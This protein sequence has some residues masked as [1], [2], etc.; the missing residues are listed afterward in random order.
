MKTKININD[1]LEELGKALIKAL[2]YSTYPEER[3]AGLI[4][5]IDQ[6]VASPT[7]LLDCEIYFRTADSNDMLLY[8]SNILYNLKMQSDFQM[9]PDE[10]KWLGSVWKNFLNRNITYQGIFKKVDEYKIKFKSYYQ[11]S[12]TFINQLENVNLI[13]EEFIDNATPENT[14]LINLENFYQQISEILS[15]MKP[16]YYFMLDYYYEGGKDGFQP[17]SEEKA[18]LKGLASFGTF[19]YTYYDLTILACQS[20]GVLEAAYLIMKKKKTSKRIITIDG[21][22]KFLST[23]EIYTIYLNKFGDMKKELARLKQA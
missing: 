20:L 18:K 4:R 15:W 5:S 12:G 16:T 1:V 6:I 14:P 3:T 9:T 19:N 21:K 10:L 13:K 7:Y 2:S 22:Q 8:I 23:S 11:I 17:A